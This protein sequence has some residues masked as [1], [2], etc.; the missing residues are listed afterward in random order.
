MIMQGLINVDENLPVMTLE[1]SLEQMLT[2]ILT[3]SKRNGSLVIEPKLAEDLFAAIATSCQQVEE[4][5]LP[6]VLVVSPGL[7]PWLSRT[8]RQRVPRLTVLSYSE[9]PDDQDIKIISNISIRDKQGE[10]A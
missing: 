8:A 6:T 1:P 7:R 4:Q 2:T 3:Q 5:G 10:T 9:I